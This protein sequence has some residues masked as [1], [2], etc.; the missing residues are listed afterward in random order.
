MSAL[1]MDLL[2][3]EVAPDLPCGPALNYDA[4]YAELERSIQGKPEQQIGDTVIPAE[5]PDWK[6][7]RDRALD[8][9]KKTKDL[10]VFLYLAV[11][12]T[13]V[14]GMPGL[15]DGLGVIRGNLEKYWDTL[16]PQLDPSD[17][18]DPTERMNI[19]A[20]VAAPPETFGDPL[21]V[22]RR[23]IEAPL[24]VSPQAGRFSL[25]DIKIAAG[26]LPVPANSKPPDAALIEA[27]FSDTP[28]EDLRGTHAAVEESLASVRAIDSFLTEK[29]G[30]GKAPDLGTF[31]KL[32][33]E[34]G[35][36][37]QT[38][39]ARRG[40]GSMPGA[41]GGPG[42]GGGGSAGGEVNTSQDVLL[43]LDKVCRYYERHE[44]SSPVPLLLKGAQRLVSQNFIEIAKVLTPETI[45]RLK[46]IAGIKSSEG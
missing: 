3:K 24:A 43:A 25:R 46:E 17:N 6:D 15:R 38:Q 34:V 11:A 19:V 1:D 23:V 14:T 13:R 30:S 32:L 12:Q 9:S 39:L 22:Q 7:V 16:H 4:A 5:E 21:A 27:A 37:L 44:V 41:A 40:V 42:S 45:D 31:M 26:D 2:L 20:S 33:T 29:V 8:L 28:L 35:N 36:V 10:R 18:N